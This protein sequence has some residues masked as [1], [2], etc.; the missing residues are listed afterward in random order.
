MKVQ[1]IIK[2]KPYLIWYTKNYDG[3]NDE[4]V[5]EAVLNYGDWDD[6]RT[7]ISIL[8]MKKVA[9]IF[10]QQII[11]PRNNYYPEIRNYFQLYFK[12]HA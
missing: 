7:L 10:Q 12:K 2:K 6:V 9:S 1:D 3:L 4:A 5:V 11:R 8:G